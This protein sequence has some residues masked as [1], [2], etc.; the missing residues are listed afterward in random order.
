[1]FVVYHRRPGLREQLALYHV[2]AGV[3]GVLGTLFAAPG[4]AADVPS[5]DL[6]LARVMVL[7]ILLLF[8]AVMTVGVGL[9][10][11]GSWPLIGAAI[12]QLLQVPV[13]RSAVVDWTFFAGGYVA[14]LWTTGQGGGVEF[15]LKATA[16]L[17]WS[18]DRPPFYAGVNL[19]PFFV[20]WLL[21]RCWRREGSLVVPDPGAT[22]GVVDALPARSIPPAG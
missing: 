18:A 20:L 22:L 21:Y 3:A 14:P 1:M 12:V 17:G 6:N 15:G 7:A 10:G 11:A 9:Y 4:I 2:L 16:N 5:V 13:V 19:V 8:G